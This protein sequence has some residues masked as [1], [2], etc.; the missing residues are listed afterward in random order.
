MKAPIAFAA[1]FVLAI[2]SS[3]F[4]IWNVIIPIKNEQLTTK[5]GIIDSEQEQNGR[6]K[7]QIQ[8]LSSPEKKEQSD[9][10][11]QFSKRLD[12]EG[13]NAGTLPTHDPGITGALWNNGGV[14]C[15]SNNGA[16]F[17][18]KKTVAKGVASVTVDYSELNL[19]SPPKSVTATLL[20]NNADDANI[21]VT[22]ITKS[23]TS[24]SA[25]IDLNGPSDT[26]GR[27]LDCVVT[28]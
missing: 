17:H 16:P 14:L 25:T 26:D 24:K 9:L 21:F 18:F 13:I 1:M 15:L 2:A 8:E 22:V 7:E 27:I 10:L 28:P 19:S 3:W 12:S 11:K 5:Q 6:L 4:G 20:K 23:I